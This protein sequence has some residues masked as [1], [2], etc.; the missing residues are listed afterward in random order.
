VTQPPPLNVVIVAY[1][2]PELL[3][4]CLTALGAGL[5]VIVIDNSSSAEVREL[6]TRHGC[7]YTDSGRNV[8]FAA[9]VNR[10]LTELGPEHGDVLLLNPDAQTT[11]ETVRALQGTMRADGNE[12]VACVSPALTRDDGTAERVEWPFPTPARAWLDALGMGELRTRGGFLI[13][14]VLLLRSEAIDEVGRFDERFFLYAEET[15]WQRR[16]TNAGWTVRACPTLVAKHTG[17]ATSSDD[18]TRRAMFHASVERY[19]RK[20]H[21]AAGW[22]FFRIGVMVGAGIRSVVTHDRAAQR[23]RLV[24]YMRGPVRCIEHPE[25]L[26]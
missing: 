26:S 24:R 5:A 3:D 25:S 11:S 8:G 21:G 13:G 15:D 10:A 1:G 9:G 19:I 6:A 12:Q 14:A 16:A 23:D 22:Q 18:G 20:W 4:R 2:A 17:A 7:R